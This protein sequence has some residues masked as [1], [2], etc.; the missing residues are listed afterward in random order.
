MGLEGQLALSGLSTG[1]YRPFHTLVN[2]LLPLPG[3]GPFNRQIWTKFQTSMTEYL[4]EEGDKL[5]GGELVQLAR[6]L[7]LVELPVQVLHLLLQLEE[8]LGAAQ[9][10][11]LLVLVPQVLVL[12][13]DLLALKSHLMYKS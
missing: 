10:L 2:R 13:V 3:Q 4:F 9:L 1:I 7:H 12:R 6:V 5:A 11:Q 8:L